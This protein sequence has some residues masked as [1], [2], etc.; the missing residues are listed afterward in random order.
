VCVLTLGECEFCK[1]VLRVYIIVVI[2]VTETQHEDVVKLIVNEEFL[3][4]CI[5]VNVNVD[6]IS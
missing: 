3:E 1:V 4:L 6:R 2:S 5:F